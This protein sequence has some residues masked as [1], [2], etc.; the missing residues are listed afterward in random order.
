MPRFVG[1]KARKNSTRRLR[2]RN[3]NNGRTTMAQALHDATLGQMLLAGVWLRT[4]ARL[5]LR[6]SPAWADGE[7]PPRTDE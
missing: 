3:I 6:W 2:C 7:L 1:D 4:I 5:G